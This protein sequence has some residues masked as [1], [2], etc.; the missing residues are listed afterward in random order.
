MLKFIGRRGV[1][2]SIGSFE[3]LVIM[4]KWLNIKYKKNRC[5]ILLFFIIFMCVM[6]LVICV[7]GCNQRIQRGH[8]VCLP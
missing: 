3:H 7:Q 1:P 2:I 4:P 8:H 5:I 6:I